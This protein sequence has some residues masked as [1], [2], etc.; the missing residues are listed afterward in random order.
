MQAVPFRARLKKSV[1]RYWILYLMLL[2]PLAWVVIFC[3]QP[4]YGLQI[5]FRDFSIRKGY[6]GSPWVGLKHF[7]TFIGGF[8]FSAL[9]KNTVILS[10]YTIL[11]TFFLPIVF[12]LMLN[13]VGNSRLKKAVQMITYLPHFISTVIVVSILRQV[14]S[15]SGIVNS[16]LILL[17][18]EPVSFFSDA[19]SFRHMYVWSGLWSELGYSTIIYM[20][21]LA[22][23]DVQLY[24]AAKIDGANRFQK[25]VH[26]DYPTIVPSMT[27]LLILRLSSVMN[28][29]F[30]KV[31]LMQDTINYSVSNIISTYVYEV[32][33]VGGQYSFSTAVGLFNSVINVALLV[34]ANAVVR[35]IS[36]N[37]LW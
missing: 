15:G 31:Y 33:L 10:L 16:L 7:K 36:E 5:A 12:A 4:M 27:T 13:E 37:S 23:A 28:V 9:I 26:I 29:G 1:R 17:G 19:S 8:Y 14:F 11:V 32:G 3:Y 6:S 34:A 2:V 21:A 20:A 30:E 24:D 35:R 25:I 18:M 22:N